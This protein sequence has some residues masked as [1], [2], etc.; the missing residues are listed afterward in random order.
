MHF[1]GEKKAMLSQDFEFLASSFA[2][3]TRQ[4]RQVDLDDVTGTMDPVS[5]KWFLE[6]YDFYLQKLDH[7]S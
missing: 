5:K 4:G 3:M 6:R 7:E 1:K 2:Q